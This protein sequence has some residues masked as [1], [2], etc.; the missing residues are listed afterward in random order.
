[1]NN[2]NIELLRVQVKQLSNDIERMSSYNNIA[3]QGSI[4]GLEL[5][6]IEL[7][8]LIY[9]LKAEFMRQA[10][11]GSRN[12]ESVLAYHQRNSY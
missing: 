8:N 9:R 11:Y 6:S 4:R 12:P 10:G 2:V 1:M 7:Q 5:K 3:S